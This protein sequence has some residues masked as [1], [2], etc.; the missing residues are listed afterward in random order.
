MMD[1]HFED[2]EIGDVEES[3]PLRAD[4][5]EMIAYAEANDPFPIHLDR[6]AATAMGFGDVIASFGYTISLY[7]Q[8]MHKLDTLR[9]A[10]AGFVGALGWE[11]TFGAAVRPGDD[12][13]MRQTIVD[14]RLTSCGDRALIT[15]RNEL[16][17]Q[18]DEIPV[19]IV[20]KWLL[21]TR[22]T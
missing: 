15:S 17:N 11:V 3:G 6:A 19:S 16:L 4:R 12:L 5:D 7:L 14:K 21:A 1:L 2:I 8:L 18:C 13:R 20:V 9:A 10:R 22:P